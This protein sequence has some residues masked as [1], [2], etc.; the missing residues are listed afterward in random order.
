MTTSLMTHQ[1][2]LLDQWG[3]L[4][5]TAFE[6]LREVSDMNVKLME[7]LSEQQREIMKSCLEA[8]TREA[9][10]ISGS[11]DYKQL[12]AG[13]AA[14]AAEYNERFRSIVSRTTD[15]LEECRDELAAWV[16]KSVEAAPTGPQT[17]G[18]RRG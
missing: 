2:E 7:K 18:R 13:Q 11:N 6:S 3:K 12:L 5:G 10:L 17:R 14:L 15:I 4:T 16:T 9:T 8:S 1:K